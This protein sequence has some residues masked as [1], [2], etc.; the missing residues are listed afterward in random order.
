VTVASSINRLA[1]SLGIIAI[2]TIVGPVAVTAVFGLFI[3]AVG[4]PVLQILLEVAELE[5]LRGWLSV[6]VFLLVFFAL[7]AAVIPSVVAGVAFAV[8][9]VYGGMNSLWVA[10][11]IM[12][13]VVIG[14]I[15]LGFVV[16][17][18]ESSPLLLP[19]VKGLRQGAFLAL[20]LSIPAAIATTLC[21]LCSRPLCRPS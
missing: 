3:V 2:F 13:A 14:L 6:A 1:R 4:I 18:E 20:F 7:A 10:L 17:P 12:A 8:A 15:A 5:T 11:A 16:S 19:S 21:W 9:S